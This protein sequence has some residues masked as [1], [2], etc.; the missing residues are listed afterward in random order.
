MQLHGFAL[1]VRDLHVALDDILAFEGTEHQRHVNRIHPVTQ[2]DAGFGHAILHLR[3]FMRD[4]GQLQRSIAVGVRQPQGR[5]EEI[6][7]TIGHIGTLP[8]RDRL[9]IGLIGQR[10]AQIV[11]EKA[12]VFVHLIN[13]I[14][15]GGVDT[16]QL[17]CLHLKG[18][19]EEK[20]GQQFFHF[21]FSFPG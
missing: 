7:R 13:Q 6:A 12:T 5:R 21:K 16:N 8:G 15:P 10:R 19:K 3:T 18:C 17:L 14:G 4:I 20:E 9:Q 1:A 2:P 11:L